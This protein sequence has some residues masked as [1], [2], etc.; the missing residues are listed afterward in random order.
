MGWKEDKELKDR[1]EECRLRA[2]H[3]RRFNKPSPG[4]LLCDQDH[5]FTNCPFCCPYQEGEGELAQEKVRRK[6]QRGGKVRRKQREPRWCNMCIAYEHED[7]D[8]PEQ[9]P[10]DEEPECPAPE[11]EEP[12]RPAPEWEEP[13]RPAPEWEEPECP[14]P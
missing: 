8:C 3:P 9:E 4:C 1:E 6:R 10:E 11:W 5:L 14:A 13:E 7:E 12:E 2:R